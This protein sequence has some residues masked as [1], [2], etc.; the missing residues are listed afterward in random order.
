M[1]LNAAVT[2][3]RLLNSQP[4]G[5]LTTK[6][7]ARKWL[8]ETGNEINIRSVQRYL[9]ELSADGADGPALVD[10]LDN[11]KERRYHLRL[12]QVAGWFMTE[13]AAMHLLLTRQVLERS[14]GGLD[15]DEARRLTDMAEMVTGDFVRTRRLRERLRIV[16]DGIG[17]LPARVDK[18]ILASKRE[19]L[20]HVRQRGRQG[21]QAG[22]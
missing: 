12:S 7:I 19:A 2:L 11:E 18:Q 1:K 21:I 4:E 16:P 22:R 5:A 8:D 20:S 13:E 15:P 17:R 9:G 10:V 14:F 6:Q 3:L